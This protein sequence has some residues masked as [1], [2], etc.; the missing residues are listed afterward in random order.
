[1]ALTKLKGHRIETK[2]LRSKL[3]RNDF[4]LSETNKMFSDVT[5]FFLL[6]IKEDPDGVCTHGI[7]SKRYYEP[8]FFGDRPTQT[9]PFEVPQTF[10]R[11]ALSKACGIY[12]SWKS[13]YDNWVAL[14]EKRKA[15]RTESSARQTLGKVN[16][17]GKSD[18]KH[19]PPILPT[20]LLL[21]ANLYSG[22]FK[23]DTGTTIVLKILVKGQW[24][25]VKFTY[26]SAAIHSEWKKSTPAIITKPDGSVWLNWTIER[27]CIATG[28]I[29]TLMQD[30]NRICAVDT[31][32]DG[33]IM[34]AVILDVDA[35]GSV[36]ELARTTLS[37]HRSHVKRRKL[38]LGKIAKLMS[39][40]GLIIKGFA[41]TRWEQIKRCEREAA[42]QLSAQLIDFA[43]R[44]RCAVIVFE[45]LGNLKP[46]L[47]RYS[48]RSN[49]KRA[50]W[51]KSKVMDETSRKARQ[52]HNILSAKVNPR[53]TSKLSAKDGCE[54]LRTSDMDVAE[55][56]ANNPK[57]WDNFK[58]THGYHPGS[59]AVTRNGYI[60]NS[61]YNAARN[62]GIKFLT[63]YY[64]SPTLVTQGFDKVASKVTG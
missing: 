44:W 35:D 1:M 39:K 34:K 47:G 17:R 2:T 49:Q 26:K 37:G 54:V 18:K 16:K 8:R 24:K 63:R 3:L 22:M 4:D 59:L 9:F 10:R 53:N 40:T 19:C 5:L 52:N 41:S 60:I 33:E 15:R 64:E 58:R 50:Y 14:V 6:V 45:F 12:K 38:R 20:R 7:D 21:N 11:A 42:N 51:L 27:Y 31:D 28:G 13:N 23:E 56:M 36:N 25:W 32:L 30:G 43:H 55:L 61:G 48:R 62:I 29:K 57:V 46:Q